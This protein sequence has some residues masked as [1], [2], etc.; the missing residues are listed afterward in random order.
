MRELRNAMERAM[1]LHTGA[2]IEVEDLP[3]SIRE[4]VAPTMVALGGHHDI[5]DHIADLERSAIATALEISRGNQT[6]AAKQL[7]ISRRTL[8]YRMEKHGLKPLPPG[9]KVMET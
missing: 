4:I 9:R 5:R 8:I 7:G 1:V 3:D 2:V 6:E